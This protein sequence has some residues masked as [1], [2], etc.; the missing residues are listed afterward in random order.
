MLS[1]GVGRM[2][3]KDESELQ[4]SLDTGFL[5]V[6]LLIAV[7]ILMNV[8]IDAADAGQ[9][10]GNAVVSLLLAGIGSV[11]VITALARSGPVFKKKNIKAER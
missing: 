9:Q 2:G 11:L 3:I 6:V 7:P 4:L 10:S 8:G 5:G 1:N